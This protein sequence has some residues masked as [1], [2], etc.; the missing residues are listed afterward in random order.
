MIFLCTKRKVDK[1]TTTDAFDRPY[2]SRRTCKRFLI[3]HNMTFI[4]QMCIPANSVLS[5]FRDPCMCSYS[6]IGSIERHPKILH[7]IV[8]VYSKNSVLSGFRDPCMCSY[9]RIGSIER[10][11]KILHKIVEQGTSL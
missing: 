3:L 6:R 11:P 1:S 8:D 9:S 2:S 5:G 4:Y 10:H 7:K